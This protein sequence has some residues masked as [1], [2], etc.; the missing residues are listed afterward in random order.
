MAEENKEKGVSNPL[1][2]MEVNLSYPQGI[3]I[4]M[5]D[6]SCVKDFE[7]WGAITSVMS[8]FVIGI[9]VGAITSV[10][11]NIRLILFGFTVVFA[12]FTIGAFVMTYIKRKMMKV[13]KKTLKMNLK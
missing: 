5:V 6:I 7:I 11:T 12:I 3:D 10:D 1:S 4:N 8:N 2:D 9:L 13:N